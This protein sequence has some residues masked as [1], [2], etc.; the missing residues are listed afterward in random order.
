L[1]AAEA[2]SLADERGAADAAAD[3]FAEALVTPIFF[4]C[5]NTS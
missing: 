5:S 3:A 4:S 2:A 1:G